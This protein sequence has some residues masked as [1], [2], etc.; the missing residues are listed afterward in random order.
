MVDNH[1]FRYDPSHIVTH[2]I[3]SSIVKFANYL[4][5]VKFLQKNG[6]TA[7]LH[8]VNLMVINKVLFITNWF[9]LLFPDLI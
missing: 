9:I 5:Q 3:Q 7:Y 4:M 6:W 8:S 1:P 2:R